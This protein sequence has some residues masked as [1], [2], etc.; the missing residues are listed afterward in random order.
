MFYYEI[1]SYHEEGSYCVQLMHEKRFMDEEFDQ[2]IQSTLPSFLPALIEEVDGEMDVNEFTWEHYPDQGTDA[3]ARWRQHCLAGGSEVLLS[4]VFG[5]V[6]DALVAEHGF[7]QLEFTSRFGA[8]HFGNMLSD[9]RDSRRSERELRL[10][11]H[12]RATFPSRYPPRITP[13]EA[14][15]ELTKQAQ[16]MGLYG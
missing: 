15:T 14:L 8:Y 12:I 16:E 3:L 11:K 2:L 6:V 9:E 13:K 10:C 7:K 5:P 1:G 4:D